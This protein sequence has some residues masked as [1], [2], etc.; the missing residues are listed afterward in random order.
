MILY[1]GS[2]FRAQEYLY[3]EELEAYHASG[4]LTHLRLAFSRDQEEKV[5][6]QHKIF[7]DKL[8]LA[9]CLLKEEG[10]FYLCGPTWPAGDV[11]D[12]IVNSFVGSGMNLE[13]AQTQIFEM[14]ENGRYVLEVY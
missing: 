9:D 8:I 1:F 6:I 11:Y 12:A 3:G 7:A 5:Y 2:R 10:H 14:K 13:D 4:V